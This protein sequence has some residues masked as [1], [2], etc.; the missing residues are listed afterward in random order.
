MLRNFGK[1]VL[2]GEGDN[3]PTMSS[4]E[5]QDANFSHRVSSPL[6]FNWLYSGLRSGLEQQMAGGVEHSVDEFRASAWKRKT[7]HLP[8]AS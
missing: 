4:R 1:S 6:V 3:V 7:Q 5:L 2:A 8:D